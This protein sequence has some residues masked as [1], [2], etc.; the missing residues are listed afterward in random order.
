MDGAV[1]AVRAAPGETVPAS[2]WKV[3]RPAEPGRDYLVLLS[4][5]PLRRFRDFPAFVRGDLGITR[6]LQSARGLIGY[7]KLGRPWT[8]RF[9]TLSAWEDENALAEFVRSGAHVATMAALGPRIGA[10]RFVRWT[11]PG[12][13]LPPTWD[14]A[15]R[16]F[17]AA[18]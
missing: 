5:L 12:R 11:L 8:K 7:S 17:R 10:T 4:Y 1:G 15:L 14:D 16:R 18:S 2:P 13:A 9:W 6:Q 3:L